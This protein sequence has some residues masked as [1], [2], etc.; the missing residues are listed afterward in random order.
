MTF[1]TRTFAAILVAS[2]LA[3]AASTALVTT[4]LRRAMLADIEAS[5][6]KQVRLA[7]ELLS[8]RG[9]LSSPDDEAAV[10]ARLIGSRVTFM[11]ADGVVIGDSDVAAND[12][13]KVDNHLAREEVQE[14]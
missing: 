6:V 3:L 4:S 12:L 1:R 8:D 14:A 11:R 13:D 5:L 2:S 10:I 9:S 7:A